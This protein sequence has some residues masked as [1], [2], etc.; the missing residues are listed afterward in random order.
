MGKL[1]EASPKVALFFYYEG[2]VIQGSTPVIA[3]K[4]IQGWKNHDMS[5]YDFWDIY[6]IINRKFKD[7]EYEEIP[8][9]RVVYNVDDDKFILY[10]D[11]CLKKPDILSQLMG[12]FSLPMEKTKVEFDGHYV[13]NNC[14]NDSIDEDN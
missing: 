12:A 13:C 9:G 4:E 7:I 3:A 5:H 6:K 11:K 8:R 2:K 14:S 10:I 1:D